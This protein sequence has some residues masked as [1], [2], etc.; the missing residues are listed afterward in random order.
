MQSGDL[1]AAQAAYATLSQNQPSNA[2]GGQ[3]NPFAKALDQ[4]GSALQSGDISGA[5]K[6]LSAL[7]S[8]AKAH[9]PPA[10]GGQGGAPSAASSLGGGGSSRGSGGGSSKASGAGGG[11]S[12]S[13]SS[14]N[15]T[16]VVTNADG[17]TTTTVKKADGTIVSE[18]R[19][20]PK[21]KD[22]TSTGSNGVTAS[23]DVSA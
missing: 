22:K 18:T 5:Q 3:N 4:I 14:Q 12:G 9:Q 10:G 8:E 11:G 23:L 7:Q 13:S 16:T 6:A 1:K 19:T 15:T 2:P 21:A 17:S 20:E